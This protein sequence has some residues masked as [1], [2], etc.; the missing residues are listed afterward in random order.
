MRDLHPVQYKN[1]SCSISQVNAIEG[2]L[3]LSKKITAGE[4]RL[5]RDFYLSPQRA[6][7]IYEID[8]IPLTK[9]RRARFQEVKPVWLAGT[10]RAARASA[11]ASNWR[12]WPSRYLTKHAG[13]R[14]WSPFVRSR[15]NYLEPRAALS[16]FPPQGSVID[17]PT[18]TGI[19]AP[20]S[21]PSRRV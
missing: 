13:G 10:L 15:C 16:V 2:K 20:E 18:W 19:G 8:K 9:R 7:H 4:R 21:S 11:D 17:V 12:C 3:L 5:L 14:G 6:A 1:I